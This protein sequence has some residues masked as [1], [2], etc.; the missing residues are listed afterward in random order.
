[1][2]HYYFDY[3]CRKWSNGVIEIFGTSKG[4]TSGSLSVVTTSAAHQWGTLYETGTFILPS[5][6]ETLKTCKYANVTFASIAGSAVWA[7][8]GH[9]GNLTGP[10]NVYFCRATAGNGLDDVQGNICTYTI[11]TWK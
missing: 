10:G 5:Y 2:V 3:T 1:L 7:E 6:P 9:W 11:G 4:S 8:G